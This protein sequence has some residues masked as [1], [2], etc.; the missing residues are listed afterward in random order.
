MVAFPFF[1]DSYQRVRV[2]RLLR[3]T[4]ELVTADLLICSTFLFLSEFFNFDH[5]HDSEGKLAY[6]QNCAHGVSDKVLLYKI[7]RFSFVNVL[8]FLRILVLRMQTRNE[9]S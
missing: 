5:G 8:L 3:G 4:L 2:N 9:K 1:S 7:L 6:P